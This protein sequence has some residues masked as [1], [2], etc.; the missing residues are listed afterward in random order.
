[1][2]RKHSDTH[3]L[4]TT[5]IHHA[6]RVAIYAAVLG[7][8]VGVHPRQLQALM[9][10]AYIHDIGKMYIPE[11]ILNKPGALTRTERSIVERH[12]AIGH[13]IGKQL[14]FPEPMLAIVRHHHERW[15]G[16]GYPDG[17]YGEDTPWL[18]RLTSVVDAYDA[19]TTPRLYRP[20]ISNDRARQFIENGA[21]TQFD[22][23]LATAW[24][25]ILDS[26]ELAHD[27]LIRSTLASVSCE[28]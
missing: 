25:T 24:L 26:G 1:M 20:A 9:Q 8:E 3:H 14:N 7:R 10:G 19:L 16:S 13:Q 18:A 2:R 6:F 27:P 21:G 15:D 22:P 12:P 17:L 5:T 28:R 23:A 11:E 4:D